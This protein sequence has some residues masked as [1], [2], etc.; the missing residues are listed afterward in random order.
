MIELKGKEKVVSVPNEAPKNPLVSVLVQ[1][2]NHEKYIS[3][4]LDGILSQRTD[5][6]FEILVGEDESSDSTREICLEYA[7]RNPEKIRLFL[8]SRANVIY[9]SNNPTGRYNLL[10]N[11][12]HANG[13]YIALCEGDDYW[14]D[15]F[16]LQKQID[17]LNKNADFSFCFHRANVL[18]ENSGIIIK[19]SRG[20]RLNKKY[21]T[22]DV[23][24][25]L[26]VY[27]NS[28][29]FKNEL[30]LPDW[31]LKIYAGDKFMILLISLEGFGYCLPDYIA[32]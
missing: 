6:E 14:I 1:T 12:E 2:Y 30:D 8:H 29:V 4:C 32:V 17:F 5:F 25:H 26:P 15:N 20:E 31:F 10:F 7:K 22:K 13:K 21:K 9:V 19:G 11:L 18:R 27:T 23:I 16:K 24:L 3:K 28:L